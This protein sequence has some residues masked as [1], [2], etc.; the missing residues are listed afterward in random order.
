MNESPLVTTLIILASALGI[1]AVLG[2]V[3]AGV[4]FLFF[5]NDPEGWDAWKASNAE[6]KKRAEAY[7]KAKKEAADE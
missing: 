6:A 2:L 4:W 3:V 5:G 7:R 1:I